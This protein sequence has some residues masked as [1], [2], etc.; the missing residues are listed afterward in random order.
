M[1]LK[2][3]FYII[4]ALFL[5]FLFLAPCAVD[6]ATYFI[7]NTLTT[8]NNDGSTWTNAFHSISD[9]ISVLNNNDSDIIYIKATGVPY[10]EP[11]NSF[12][13]QNKTIYGDAVGGTGTETARGSARAEF[14][15]SIDSTSFTWVQEGSSNVYR[16]DGID[17][18]DLGTVVANSLRVVAWY[19]VDSSTITNILGNGASCPATITTLALNKFCY[20][21]ATKQIWINIGTDP[22]GKH[23]E[24]VKRDHV[25]EP[26]VGEK[27]YGIVAKHGKY[28][29]FNTG[30]DN[31]IIDGTELFYNDIG[32]SPVAGQLDTSSYFRRSSIH[33]NYSGGI[34]I[35]GANLRGVHFQNNLIYNN[36]SYGIYIRSAN[37]TADPN[38]M[39]YIENNTIYGNTG[40]G[41]YLRN[42]NAGDMGYP[43]FFVTVKNNIVFGNTTAQ[44][45]LYNS[46]DENLTASNNAPGATSAYGGIWS[47]Y[48]GTGNVETD[49]L[50][51][52]PVTG[53][54][55]LQ[56]SSP[57]IDAGVDVGITSDYLGT[58]VPQNTTPDIGAYEYDSAAPVIS[59]G[60]DIGLTN[61]NTPSFTFTTSE[62]GTLSYSGD[63]SSAITSAT[64][65]SNT[66]S[67]NLLSDGTYSN[68][69]VIVTDPAGNASNQLSASSFVVDTIAPTNIGIS[70]I[71]IDSPTQLTI[72]AN[73]AVD[74][75]SGLALAPYWFTETTGHAGSSSSTDWQASNIFTDSG[76]SSNIGYGYKVKVRDL[77]GNVSEYSSE[78]LQSPVPTGGASAYTPIIEVPVA[79]TTTQPLIVK[80]ELE[81]AVLT[82]DQIKAKISEIQQQILLISSQSSTTSHIFNKNLYFGDIDLEVKYL[83]QY[84]NSH[85]FLVA[86]TGPGSFGNETTKF[87]YA[88]KQALSKFQ[89]ANTDAIFKFSLV[90]GIGNFGPKTRKFINEGQ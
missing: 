89:E 71:V 29:I 19:Y 50:M 85:G 1:F 13:F 32:A 48:K 8:G 65:G 68:C 43:Y 75:G 40:Y 80:E 56:S 51:V 86:I 39:N 15:G 23:I 17:I 3:N 66:I 70:S 57:A 60:S 73:V 30:C 69:K 77:A 33:N 62:A 49:P 84:L 72:T 28:G 11:L 24:I 10:R 21:N 2:Y 61:D 14:W 58:V 83:Q 87:G 74:Y 55:K 81:A 38:E 4:K 90:S 7:D 52:S 25:I 64:I 34:V 18:S 59:G 63:C 76:L 31:W 79:E 54:F 47:T 20:N 35:N 16:S 45:Y 9:L 53:N 41:I 37:E 36:G 5:V 22:N 46:T 26:W 88:T 12:K 44:L 78:V 67:F 42:N 27:I 82:V 6:A